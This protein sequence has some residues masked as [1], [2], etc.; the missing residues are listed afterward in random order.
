MLDVSFSRVRDRAAPCLLWTPMGR[1]RGASFAMMLRSLC[2]PRSAVVASF[3]VGV[4]SRVLGE[5]CS[6]RQLR[7][8]SSI[9]FTKGQRQAAVRGGNK[10]ARELPKKAHV[11][12]SSGRGRGVGG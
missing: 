9:P 5:M 11:R 8:F 10:R 4:I 12:S 7:D 2:A 6:L 1:G 3:L